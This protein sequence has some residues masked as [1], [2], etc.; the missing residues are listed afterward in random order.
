MKEDV[1]QFIWKMKRLPNRP[2]LSTSGAAVSI[3]DFGESNDNQGPDFL[4]GRVRIDEIEFVGSIEIHVNGSDWLKHKHS[5]SK[6]YDNV[7]LHVVY[8]NDVEIINSNKQPIPTLV[9]KDI[10]DPYIIVNYRS[11]M[12][13]KAEIPCQPMLD[14]VDPV[15]WNLA[16]DRLV[17]ERLDRKSIEITMELRRNVFNWEE[18]FYQLLFKYAAMGVNSTDFFE[19]AKS[20]PLSV[21]NKFGDDTFS[22]EAIYFGQANLLENA[23]GQYAKKLLREYKYQKER[24]RL[25]KN[26]F[27]L[28]FS[29][30]RP[31]NFPT[32]RLGQLSALL[33]ARPRL[34][35]SILEANSKEELKSLFTVLPKGYFSTHL[36][37]N[38]SGKYSIGSFGNSTVDILILNLV[39]P[40]LY[41]YGNYTGNEHMLQKAM[42]IMESV[43][44]ENNKIT[45]T[46]KKLNVNSKNGYDSQAL[47]E[48]YLN[49]CSGKKC[50]NCAL[51]SKTLTAR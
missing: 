32:V 18:T 20:V 22:V 15:F 7:V 4:N 42:W 30:I 23:S 29:R 48:L 8:N 45:R 40:V 36:T 26:Y 41:T 5:K 47:I 17:V 28:K 1:L 25:K 46:W 43:E 39:V 31:A 9:L 10:I 24:M 2:L 16:K 3:I 38:S 34:F 33:V 49:Y 11:I 14:Q 6:L 19:L 51:G 27:Q 37:F 13:S 21:I 35:H 12:E 44:K 50:L